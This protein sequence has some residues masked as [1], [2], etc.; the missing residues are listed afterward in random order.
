LGLLVAVEE[1]LEEVGA[2]V[3]VA[4]GGV[5]TLSLEYRVEG[6]VG[7]VVGARFTDRFELEPPPVSRR[8]LV[9]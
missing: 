8:L 4:V 5:V 7:R 3:L 1:H 9:G 2:G 6:G